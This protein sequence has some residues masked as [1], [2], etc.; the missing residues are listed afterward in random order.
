M[1]STIKKQQARVKHIEGLGKGLARVDLVGEGIGAGVLPGNFAM[2]QAPGRPDCIL[3]RPYSYFRVPDENTVSLLIRDVGKGSHALVSAPVGDPVEILGPLGN[4]FPM[5]GPAKVW[6]V[7]GGVGAAP[8]GMMPHHPN[9]TVLFG[10]RTSADAGFG[11]ALEDAGVS[12]E[13]ATDDGSAGFHGTTVELLRQKLEAG[14]RPEGIFTCGP[15]PMMAAA[16]TV[17][18]EFEIPCWASLEERM[19]CG[20]GICR[21]CVQRDVDGNLI[22]LC[23]DGPVY[24]ARRIFPVN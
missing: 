11:R 1:I 21:G 18:A 3:F 19:G 6:A 20:I 14:E 17:A 8:F 15:T 4:T 10:S 16:T 12:V 24:D 9:L 5:E 23:V 13:L 7:A 2:V 22:C